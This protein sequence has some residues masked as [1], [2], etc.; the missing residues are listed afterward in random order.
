MSVL[1]ALLGKK[2]LHLKDHQIDH[3]IFEMYSVHNFLTGSKTLSFHAG[4]D[5]SNWEN[6]LP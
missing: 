4:A 5:L 3:T 6:C 1:G 2:K